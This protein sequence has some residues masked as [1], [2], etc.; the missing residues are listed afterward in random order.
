MKTK[1]EILAEDKVKIINRMTKVILAYAELKLNFLQVVTLKQ[2]LKREI[3]YFRSR[4]IDGEYK[5]YPSF[6]DQFFIL[7]SVYGVD[8]KENIEIFKKKIYDAI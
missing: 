7:L 3:V 1:N 5:N 8:T 6:L 2:E 4:E